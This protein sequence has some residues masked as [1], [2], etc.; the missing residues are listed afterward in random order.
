MRVVAGLRQALRNPVD[1]YFKAII[2]WHERNERNTPPGQYA[3]NDD[4]RQQLGVSDDNREQT[5]RLCR[6]IEALL[7]AK[8]LRPGPKSYLW[9]NDDDPAFMRAIWC[10]I[11]RLNAPR[12]SRPVRARRYQPHHSGGAE[13][14]GTPLEH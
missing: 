2:R 10:L 11:R 9:W 5:D 13:G 3:I 4:W 6:S 14:A 7:I 12:S 1:A 8:G